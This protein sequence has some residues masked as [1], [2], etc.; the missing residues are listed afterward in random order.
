MPLP[1]GSDHVF[2]MDERNLGRSLGFAV[3]APVG[4]VKQGGYVAR[5]SGVDYVGS[6]PESGELVLLGRYEP[7]WMFPEDPKPGQTWV[8]QTDMFGNTENRGAL[9]GWN[10]EVRQ[11]TSVRVPAGRF[12]NHLDYTLPLPT[13][14]GCFA[15]SSNGLASG[16]HLLEAISHGICEVVER[17]SLTMWHL[18][19]PEAQ[20]RTRIALDSIDDPRC[21]SI[22]EKYD[23][24]G[25]LVG[26]W[27]ITSDVGVPAFICRTLQ[28]EGPRSHTVRPASGMGC[29]PSRKVALLRA[30]TEAAQ[31]RLTFISGARDDMPRDEYERFLHPQTQKQWRHVLG[32]GTGVRKFCE[33]PTWEKDTFDDDVDWELERLRAVGIE[34]VIVVNLA[35]PEFEIPVVRMIIPGLEGIDHSPKYAPGPRAR[36]RLQAAA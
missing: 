35:K 13:G 15:P 31:S 30:L 10:G 11:L 14:H 26:V 5:V 22:L 19:R 6:D 27:E 36:T 7:T 4:Y 18:L 34:Q 3:V 1:G 2:I 25:V 28:V 21:R 33:A 23:H 16:N 29:H 12:E 17:D 32:D 20:E 24:A 8:Q 9:L